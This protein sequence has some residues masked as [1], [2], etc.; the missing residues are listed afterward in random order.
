MRVTTVAAPDD[1]LGPIEGEVIAIGW[2]VDPE[3]ADDPEHT[4]VGTLYLVVDERRARP[5]WIRQGDLSSV[6]LGR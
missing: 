3:A 6:H 4:P 1:G 2:W 5:M